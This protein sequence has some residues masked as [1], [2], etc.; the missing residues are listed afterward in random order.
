MDSC[1]RC[2]ALLPED[3]HYCPQCGAPV[4]AEASTEARVRELEAELAAIRSA[5]VPAAHGGTLRALG[6]GLVGLQCLLVLGYGIRALPSLYQGGPGDVLVAA[7]LSPLFWIGIVLAGIADSHDG[8]S[9]WTTRVRETT[10]PR[11]LGM[12][13]VFVLLSVLIG[14]NS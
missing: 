11:L 1:R 6:V 7:I 5:P 8:K 3:A 14:G 2:S 13:V 4:T 10:A 9:P 12:Y